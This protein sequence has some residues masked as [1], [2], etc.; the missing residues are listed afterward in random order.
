MSF[1]LPRAVWASPHEDVLEVTA[2]LGLAE[3]PDSHTLQ[4][5]AL[6]PSDHHFL[7]KTSRRKHVSM[8]QLSQFTEGVGMRWL[9]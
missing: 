4:L 1:S 3:K 9:S 8:S 6:S 2:V 5:P 7:G